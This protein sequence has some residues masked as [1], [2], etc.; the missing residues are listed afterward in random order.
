[1]QGT[2]ARE[3]IYLDLAKLLLSGLETPVQNSP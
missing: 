2:P 1:M 3:V